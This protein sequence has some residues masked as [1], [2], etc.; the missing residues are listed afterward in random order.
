MKYVVYEDACLKE[1]FRTLTEAKDYVEYA[2][3]TYHSCIEEYEDDA[4]PTFLSCKVDLNNNLI[5]GDE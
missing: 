2:C 4:E 5:K 3:D 1:V